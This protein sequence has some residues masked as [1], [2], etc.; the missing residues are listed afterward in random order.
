MNPQIL[1]RPVTSDDL[2]LRLQIE[3]TL[4]V[5]VRTSLALMGFGFVVARFGLFLREIANVTDLHLRA[6]PK[7]AGMS[8]FTGTFLILLGVAVLLISVV[9]HQSWVTRL[10]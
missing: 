1:P 7:L 2:K 5:W 10:E 9:V 4:L 3:T 6:H 8:A